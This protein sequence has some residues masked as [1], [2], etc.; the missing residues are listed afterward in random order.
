[1]GFDHDVDI[2]DQDL[3]FLGFRSKMTGTFV[4]FLLRIAED[5]TADELRD[6]REDLIAKYRS[7]HDSSTINDVYS[8]LLEESC[9]GVAKTNSLLISDAKLAFDLV[10]DQISIILHLCRVTDQ[11]NHRKLQL[12]RLFCIELIEENR[13][14]LQSYISRKSQT[15]LS[16]SWVSLLGLIYVFYSAFYFASVQASH[17]QLS[18][19]ALLGYGVS[20]LSYVLLAAGLF[21][22]TFY[23]FNIKSR[24]RVLFMAI[25][26][27]CLGFYLVN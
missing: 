16:R 6:L 3:S 13:D 1:V 7:L 24:M 21:S 15:Y 14:G 25:A 23:A 8:S 12:F 9:R 10:T 20:Q 26:S 5:K 17:G 19:I 4:D 18:I 2:F 27:A 22:G 11:I